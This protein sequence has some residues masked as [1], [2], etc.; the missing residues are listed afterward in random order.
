MAH[1]EEART[2]NIGT[3]QIK[4]TIKVTIKATLKV[5]HHRRMERALITIG[6]VQAMIMARAR[7][8]TTIGEARVLILLKVVLHLKTAISAAPVIIGEA[9]MEATSS[10][11]RT[12]AIAISGQMYLLRTTILGGFR[13]Q[14]HL[15]T[16]MA[17]KAWETIK[18][19]N[20]VEDRTLLHLQTTT[21]AIVSG[22]APDQDRATPRG[23]V[24]TATLAIK[25]VRMLV[26]HQI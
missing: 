24:I 13:E 12:L 25:E 22:K 6:E 7:S 17:A 9:R 4:V 5:V 26:H 16:S 3:Y 14:L 19:V 2:P 8:L 1:R 10:E 21:L 15:R 11:L 18:E 23:W 20:G